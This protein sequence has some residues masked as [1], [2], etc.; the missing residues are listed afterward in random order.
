MSA[1]PERA[2]VLLVNSLFIERVWTLFYPEIPL[3]LASLAAVLE[4]E[5]LTVAAMDMNVETERI[6]YVTERVKALRPSYIG[7]SATFGSLS[8]AY[9]IAVACRDACDAVIAVGG[10][11]PTFIPEQILRDCPAVDI[12]VRCEGEYAM[13]DV[14]K[15][16]PP[17]EIPGIV[18]RDG[19]SIV[20]TPDRERIE[21]LDALPFPA[22]HLFPLHRY[23]MI[24]KNTTM[25]ETSRGCPFACDFCVA[26]I[27][28]GRA[29]R[30]RSPGHIVAEM[31]HIRRRHPHIRFLNIVD[32]NLLLDR[33]R[34]EELCRLVIAQG[35][36]RHFRLGMST[37]ASLLAERAPPTRDTGSFIDLLVRAG[38]RGVFLGIET[39]HEGRKRQYEKVKDFEELKRTIDL[40]EEKRLR[41]LA[42]YIIGFPEETPQDVDRTIE[43]SRYLNS[44]GIKYNI[45]TPYPGTVLGDR[46]REEG[47]LATTDYI[48]YDNVHQVV[49]FPVDIEK[50]LKRATVGYYNRPSY[51]LGAPTAENRRFR[52]AIFASYH[53]YWHYL[54]RAVTAVR[55]LGRR[56]FLRDPRELEV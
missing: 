24:K 43:I 17:S 48:L 3:G 56:L 6:A 30:A 41:V 18:Y 53:L 50:I 37:R 9:R 7:I 13:R 20:R 55:R 27:K 40:L 19:G 38:F 33:G 28:D 5:G 10:I 47:L 4:Q 22:R 35:L 49:K 34:V 1:L 51:F 46:M 32:D 15:G 21:D 14:A 8:N 12:A 45:L 23:G 16:L 29:F 2:D 54:V 25:M 52:A 42:S 11:A 26:T 31:E 39:S 36:D 44:S